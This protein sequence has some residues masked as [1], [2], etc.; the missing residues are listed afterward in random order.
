MI[1]EGVVITLSARGL[2]HITPL[3]M[4]IKAG[5]T[6]LAPFRP[7]T[8]LENLS[9]TG[10]ASMNFIDDVRVIAGCLTGRREFALVDGPSGQAPRLACALTVDFLKV[11]DVQEDPI[12][13]RFHCDVVQ[14]EVVAPFRGFNRAQSAVLEAAILYSRVG[15]LPKEK[16]EREL[17]FHT[18]A[19]EKTAG[20]RESEA[21]D[22]LMA[23]FAEH[24]VTP[25]PTPESV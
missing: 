4:R 12:R 24:D 15:M 5:R 19:M 21:W 13:P 17:G 11:A 8:T 2:P 3:G 9:A 7:S 1:H 23:A 20:G 22:W 6:V 18:I 10:V 16:L 25:R 14:T